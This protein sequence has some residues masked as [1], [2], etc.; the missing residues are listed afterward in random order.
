MDR[1][2]AFTGH[3]R[4][5]KIGTASLG[6]LVGA[7][8]LES[9]KMPM[10]ANLVVANSSELIVPRNKIPEVVGSQN[11]PVQNVTIAPVFHVQNKEQIINSL[12]QILNNSP[13]MSMV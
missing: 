9:S 11:Q 13:V 2:Q 10:G 5:N 12:S 1:L 4:F 3:T 8:K 7:A 6:N